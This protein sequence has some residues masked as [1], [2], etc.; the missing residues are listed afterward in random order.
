MAVRFVT[1]DEVRAYTGVDSSTISDADMTEIIEDVEYQCEKYLATDFAVQT[2]IENRDGNALPFIYTL[3]GPLLTVRALTINDTS[4]DLTNVK[5]SRSGKVELL[6]GSARATMTRLKNKV[7]IKYI[8]GRYEYD[9]VT[10]TTTSNAESAGTSVTVEVASDTGFS[11]NDWVEISSLDGNT[12]VCQVSSTTTNELTI[13]ELVYN[14]ASGATVKKLILNPAIERYIKLWASIMAINRAV[15]ESATDITGYTMGEFQ[16][17]KGEPF[18]QYRE[19]II[20]L[21]SQ[22]Q[23]LDKRLQPTPGI[24]V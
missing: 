2:T 19:Q 20:R 7:H 12:E 9:K 24:L 15:G 5:F 6:S 21:E 22:V 14:H 23:E 17:Q 1:V 4:I 10:N 13:D 11:A 18:T 3:K 16:V 8:H